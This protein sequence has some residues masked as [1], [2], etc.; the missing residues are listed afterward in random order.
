MS[1]DSGAGVRARGGRRFVRRA[2]RRNG[3]ARRRVGVRKDL[4]GVRPDARAGGECARRRRR[5]ASSFEGTDLLALDERAMRDLRGRRISMI[6][7]EPAAALNPVMKVGAQ[8]AEVALLHGERSKSDGVGARG[9]HA[10][11]DGNRRRGALRAP[12][13][14]RTLGRHAAARAHRHGPDDAAGAGDRRRADVRARRHGAGADPRSPA[15]PP[16]RNGDG[17]A[18]HHARFRR[19]GGALLARDGDARGQDRRGRAGR[20]DL[21][22][23]ARTRT[24][25]SCCARCPRLTA[26]R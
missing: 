12:V 22:C 24:P 2:R 5:A 26:D 8:V 9:G 18:V 11:P 15:R 7:Q 20:P 4:R 13:S 23:A 6:F 25:P 1:Y 21:P 14:A 17:R 10:R 19:R 3:R 16:A